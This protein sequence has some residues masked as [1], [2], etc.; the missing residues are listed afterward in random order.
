MTD[1]DKREKGGSYFASGKKKQRKAM[2]IAIP[3]IVA[4]IAIIA[5]GATVY[6]PEPVQA[7]DGIPCNPGESVTFHI[8]A[9]LDVFVNGK[10]ATV[11]ALI[12]IPQGK[13]YYWL[14]THTTDG[15]IHM[16]APT[17]Q[18]F[19][20]GKFVD[21][22]DRTQ[23]DSISSTLQNSPVTAYVNSNTT[24]FVGSYRDIP[25]SSKEQI[26]LVIGQPPAVI[27]KDYPANGPPQ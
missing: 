3:A 18:N 6:K 4:I 2:M 16:E 15:I 7:I 27:P 5:I 22:W 21:I 19:T 12:G 24:K 26:T 25:L 8:H 17:A 9:H 20:L 13:C 1:K 11:P 10:S 23:P 14:H